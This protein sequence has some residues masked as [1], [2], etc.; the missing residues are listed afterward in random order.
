MRIFLDNIIFSLQKAGGISG[1][2]AVLIRELLAMP[3]LDIR[4][5]EREDALQNIFRN[6]LAI[7]S[8]LI[9]NSRRLPLR[10]DRYLPVRLEGDV[11][12]VFHSSYYRICSSPTALNVVTLHDFIYE[13]ARVHSP[14][15]RRVH[16]FQKKHALYHAA[17]IAAVSHATARKLTNRLALSGKVIYNPPVCTPVSTS[18]KR[19]GFALY[20]G[21]RVSYKNFRQAAEAAAI[22]GVP[23]TIAGAPLDNE[24]SALLASLA[25]KSDFRIIENPDNNMLSRLYSSAMCLIYPSS[26]EGFGIPIVEAMTHRCPVITGPCDACIETGGGATL[27]TEDYSPEALARALVRIRMNPGLREDLANRGFEASRHFDAS[28]MAHAYISLYQAIADNVKQFP[29]FC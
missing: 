20:V 23:M 16:T 13:E 14:L 7:P 10:L 3:E 25:H 5:I 28:E 6:Q 24:E 2:W 15:A 9:I 11:P 27:V 1:A 22:A 18:M 17:A 12:F 19:N 21:S 8:S 4:F 26:H 29:D